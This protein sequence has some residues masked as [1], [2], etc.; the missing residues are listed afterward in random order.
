M[1][2]PQPFDLTS[3]NSVEFQ[4]LADTEAATVSGGLWPF[5]VP[6]AVGVGFSIYQSIKHRGIFLGYDSKTADGAQKVVTQKKASG[7]GL[8]GFLGL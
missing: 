8:F 6:I 7:R 5:A 1:S 2:N 4:D 3:T